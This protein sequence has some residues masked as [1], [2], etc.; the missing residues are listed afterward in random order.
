MVNTWQGD[1]LGKKKRAHVCDEEISLVRHQAARPCAFR[2]ELSDDFALAFL[3]VFNRHHS[4]VF[5]LER[6]EPDGWILWVWSDPRRVVAYRHRRSDGEGFG[7]R[8]KQ[9]RFDSVSI[10]RG[11]DPV[12]H[13]LGRG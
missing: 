3:I 7:F 13:D 11:Q 9:E 2:R 5:L 10:R 6:S 12:Q 1:E 4:P 8:V